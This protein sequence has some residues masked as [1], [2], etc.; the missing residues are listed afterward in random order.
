M[1]VVLQIYDS[2]IFVEVELSNDLETIRKAVGKSN[3]MFNI[4][5]RCRN[6]STRK[7]IREF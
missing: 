7:G 3:P 2:R 1:I 6:N 5:Y 4:L